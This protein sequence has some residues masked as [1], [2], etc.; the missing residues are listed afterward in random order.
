[1]PKE[2]L[3]GITSDPAMMGWM[4]GFPPPAAKRI[5]AAKGNHMRF[6]W[7][8]WS[9]SNMREFCPTVRVSRGQGPVTPLPVALRDDIDAL[10]VTLDD[11]TRTTWAATLPLNF[12]DAMCV[13]HRGA[14]VYE[15]Y[16][17]VTR[18]D[19]RHI[20]FSVTKS[21]LGL[22][23]EMLIAEGRLDPAS[24]VADHLPELA[25]TGYAD[26]T[27]RQVLDMTTAIDYSEDY[28]DARSGIGDFSLA[29]ALTPRAAGYAGPEDMYAYLATLAADG[30]HGKAFTYRTINT[31]V[32]GWIVARIQG[33]RAH[34]VYSR[35]I[36]QPLR[37]QDDA[38]MLVDPAGTP[39]TGG[40]L[41][42]TLRDMARFGEAMRNDGAVGGAQLLAAGPIRAIKSGASGAD[43]TRSPHPSLPDLV[44]RSQWWFFTNGNPVFS[45]RGI[46]GQAI[47]VD[48]A[49][50][51]TIARFAS[52]P[53]AANIPNDATTLPVFR[54]LAEHLL[55]I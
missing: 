31:E 47:Y 22:I 32:L 2:I 15:R 23:A 33:E 4:Q 26:A 38:D 53:I 11:G 21:F 48:P 16:L 14:V 52:H 1:M 18:P 45:A 49:A 35:R 9:F 39:F 28:A 13:L 8:R 27:I 6:P 36:W 29:L 24:R 46:H 25:G 40:G 41:N 12:T 17:G 19:S 20:A 3:D 30:E 5:E 10:P 7:T 34:E 55:R 50:E 43:A 51:L 37:M 54:A 42:P 44:Y